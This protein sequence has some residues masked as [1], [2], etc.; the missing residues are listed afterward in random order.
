MWRW[1]HK[2]SGWA[3]DRLWDISDWCLQRHREAE[4]RRV[5]RPDAPPAWLAIGLLVLAVLVLA[6]LLEVVAW[7]IG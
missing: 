7:L 3:G 6:G 2:A 5:E 1:L 4:R